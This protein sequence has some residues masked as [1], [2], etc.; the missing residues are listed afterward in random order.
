[1]P[2]SGARSSN[3][4]LRR[5]ADHEPTALLERV[6]LIF[7]FSPGDK[8]LAV[9]A[10]DVHIPGIAIKGLRVIGFRE[11]HQR[12]LIRFAKGRNAMQCFDIAAVRL[13]REFDDAQPVGDIWRK[14]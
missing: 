11:S 6:G 7:E 4:V 1:M 2:I 5:G 9:V 12:R 10:G 13:W 14:L 8:P 3:R